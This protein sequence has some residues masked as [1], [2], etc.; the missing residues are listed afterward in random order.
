M[1]VN[2][3]ELQNVKNRAFIKLYSKTEQGVQRRMILVV[4]VFVFFKLNCLDF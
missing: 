2:V 4:N 3:Q 1:G